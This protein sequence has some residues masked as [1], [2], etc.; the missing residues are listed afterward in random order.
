VEGE[1]EVEANQYGH[2]L[3]SRKTVTIRGIGETYSGVYYVSHVTHVFTDDGF[4][5]V[6]QV[7]RNAL[8]PTGAEEF[9]SS[10]GMLG[11]LL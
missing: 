2:I 9:A 7:K 3:K 4:R 6:F 1:G 5:Q 10:S 8:M 11:G